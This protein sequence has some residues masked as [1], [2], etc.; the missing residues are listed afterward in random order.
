QIV[1]ALAIDVVGDTDLYF[2]QT[3]EHVELGQR[4]AVDPA[5]LYGLADQ[6]GIEPAAAAPTPRHRAELS[7]TLAKPL[8]DLLLQFRWEGAGAHPGGIGLGDSKNAV[9]RVWTYAG[10]GRRLTRHGIGRSHVGIGAVVDV[11]KS[12]LGT[13]KKNPIALPVCLLQQPPHLIDVRQNLGRHRKELL[14][15]FILVDLALT[16]AAEERIVVDQQDI[17]TFGQQIR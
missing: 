6:N 13:F 9:E 10:T 3:V 12:P 11:Q 7:S 14:Q 8:P 15:Q 1:V 2:T 4:D 5:C 17:E 16:Q